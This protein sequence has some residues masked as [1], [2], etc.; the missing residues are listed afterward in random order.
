MAWLGEGRRSRGL[1]AKLDVVESFLQ[2]LVVLE[3]QLEERL[4]AD[5]KD[6]PSS[7]I[8]IYVYVDVELPTQAKDFMCLHNVVAKS[9]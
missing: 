3:C 4:S 2:I 5:K 1:L 6:T 7:I 8:P 9:N